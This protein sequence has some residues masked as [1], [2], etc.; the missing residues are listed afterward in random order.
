[1]VKAPV[2]LIK[3]LLPAPESSFLPMSV[4]AAMT[5]AVGPCQSQASAIL[6]HLRHLDNEPFDG[7]SFSLCVCLSPSC[8]VSQKNKTTYKR[9]LPNQAQPPVLGRETWGKAWLLDS[10]RGLSTNPLNTASFVLDPNM[11]FLCMEGWGEM[12]ESGGRILPEGMMFLE[13]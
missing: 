6:T 2:T 4:L 9:G 12:G 13:T 7:P 10:A 8:C 5:P 1:M 11:Q 3:V